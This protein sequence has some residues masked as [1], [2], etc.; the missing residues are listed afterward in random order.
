MFNDGFRFTGGFRFNG[1]FKLRDT[2][3][4]MGVAKSSMATTSHSIH[5]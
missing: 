2:S 5:P 3:S 1:G 4:F